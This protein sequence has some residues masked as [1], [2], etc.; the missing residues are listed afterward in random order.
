VNNKPVRERLLASSM[1]GGLGLALAGLVGTQAV[2]QE[3]A[4]GQVEVEELVVTGSRIPQP[5]MTSISPVQVVNSQDIA[6][7]GRSATV[8]VINTLP[9]VSI[10][11]TTDLGPTSNP[12]SGPGGVATANL[13]G[14][15]PTRTLVLVDGRRLGVGD[16]NTGNTNPAPDL[17]QIPSQ[18]IDRVEVLTG[19]ASAVYGSDAIAG[20]V[21]FVMKRNFEGLQFDAQYGVNQH[22]QHSK[23]MQG[24]LRDSD[25]NVPDSTWDGKS[26]DYSLIFGANAPDGRGNI[27]AYA[28]LHRQDPVTF[29]A[30]D[31]AA[32]QLNV[33]PLPRCAGSQSSNFF[34]RADATGDELAVLG[35]Q[36]IPWGTAA[37]SPPAFF[38]SNPYEYLLQDNERWTGGFF[39]N[40]EI[41]D[42]F[43]PYTDFSYMHDR[44]TVVIAPS[45]SFLGDGV[46]AGGGF[47]VNCNNPLM[48][49]QQAAAIGC[50]PGSTD[51]VELLIGRRNVE[52]GGRKQEYVHDNYRVVLGT[53]GDI[54]GPWK[55]DL[56]GSYYYTSLYQASTN[57]LSK[58][59]IQNALLVNP[60]G[61]CISGG[62]CVPWNIFSDGGV[63][64]DQIDYLSTSG[65]NRGSITEQIV[66]GTVT[67]NLADYG[68]KSPWANDGVGVAVGFQVRR[69]HL[70]FAP[71]Q[72]LLS[73]DLAGAGGASTAIDRSIRSTEFYAEVQAPIIQD[74]PWVR[75]LTLNGGY[76]RSDY[77]IDVKA[78]TWKI[79][80]EY[81]PTEDIR[82]RGGFN[83]AIRAPSILELYTPVAVTNTSVVSEDPCAADAEA[84]ATLEQ[85]LRTGIV[86][87]QYGNIVQ[88]PADQCA[89]LNGGNPALAPERA[90]TYTVGLLLTPRA[91]SNFNASV[92]FYDITV[93][94]IINTIPLGVV[95]NNCLQTG[96]DQFCS[97]IV[98]NPTNGILFGSSQEQ[99]GYIVGTN[100]NVGKQKVRGVD[101]QAAYRLG[102]DTFDHDEWG[103]LVFSFNGAL[104]LKNQTQPYPGGETYD[105]K[106]LYG[107]QC[108]TLNPK[109]RHNL[110]VTWNAP[111]DVQ[112]SA[113][114]RYI[115][116]VKL[117]NLSDQPIIGTRPGA[118]DFNGKISAEQYLDLAVNWNVNEKLAVRA[119]INN[120]TDNDPPVV[121]SAIAGS[122]SPNSYPA[123]DYLGR[124]M[125]AAFTARF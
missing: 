48:S 46:Q 37:T 104:L 76:R 29:A 93:K 65:T 94:G 11:S 25:V 86:P 15:G 14:L 105:C 45:A 100:A 3:A 44:T 106:G 13:R 8:N 28:T 69:D 61:T 60:D 81:A 122:G 75:E 20:V 5:N 32:C 87:A 118:A 34:T 102:F 31:W 59:R 85:C 17:N 114:W 115:G 6:V 89:V 109:W 64:P 108:Q 12:L 58:Q 78:D 68:G 99:G 73:N 116:K 96:D 95:L 79:G 119:G 121:R 53:K 113:T 80:A 49:G 35:N 103:S 107:T 43:K 23:F 77:S 72:A 74:M 120:I 110:R 90:N 42:H 18:L 92:D 39:A 123:Y 24:L 16:P 83:R 54:A 71:D 67:G 125:F 51:N 70:E 91:L 62:S 97:Q 10:N 26:I 55:Y 84:P 88:C 52:G 124:Q 21:N 2:A 56:Y 117:E 101:F 112:L 50:A 30:R 82:F 7:G 36:F 47:F 33:D 9:Q 66:E 27:T 40:Y 4:Q 57:Y 63:T 98:R 22:S 1:I 111:R 19:G 41:N 38:N